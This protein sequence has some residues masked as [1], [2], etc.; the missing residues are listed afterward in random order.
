ME[1]FEIISKVGKGSFG[2]VYKVKRISDGLILACKELNYGKMGE[3]E[4]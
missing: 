2:S 1:N 3:R 4:K